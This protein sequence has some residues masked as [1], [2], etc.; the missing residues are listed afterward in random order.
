MLG[1]SVRG[2]MMKKNRYAF[3]G[4]GCLTV[5]LMAALG[6]AQMDKA[7]RPSPAAKAR[8]RAGRTVKRSPVDYSSPR[9]KGAR[10][11]RIVPYGQVWRAGAN[12]ATLS[13]PH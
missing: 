7:S 5:G 2:K 3:F 11:W 9:A 6:P 13:L 1:N 10:F 8:L 4:G 12:E